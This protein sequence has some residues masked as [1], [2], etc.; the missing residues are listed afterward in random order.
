M[1]TSP[2]LPVRVPAGM[3]QAGQH[4]KATTSRLGQQLQQQMMKGNAAEQQSWQQAL[5]PAAETAAA[6]A[7]DAE[8]E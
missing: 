1:D 5:S 7:T 6:A 8:G 2:F 3:Q 4:L